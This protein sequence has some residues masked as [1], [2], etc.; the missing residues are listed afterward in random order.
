MDR[1][2][3]SNQA[4]EQAVLG[5]LLANPRTLDYCTGLTGAQ[6]YWQSNGVLFDIIRRR[7]EAGVAADTVALKGV[8]EN[9]DLFERIRWRGSGLPVPPH[10]QHGRHE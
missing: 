5:A 1:P 2:P 4:A 3:P 8:F 6:F 9:T 7:I 10:H